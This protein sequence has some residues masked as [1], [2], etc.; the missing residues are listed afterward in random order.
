MVKILFSLAAATAVVLGNPVTKS[1][2]KEQQQQA[3][4]LASDVDRVPVPVVS[5][6]Y[7]LNDQ[8]LEKKQKLKKRSV[9]EELPDGSDDYLVPAPV[10]PA[11]YRLSDNPIEPAELRLVE[12]EVFRQPQRQKAEISEGL[13]KAP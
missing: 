1:M 2:V 6:T 9:F 13:L 4:K 11:K 10:V 12:T 8:I 7:R 3:A 5:A